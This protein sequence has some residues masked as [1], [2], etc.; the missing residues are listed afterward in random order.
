LAKKLIE[1]GAHIDRIESITTEYK[2]E[3]PSKWGY[4]TT[5]L[6]L[7][8]WNRNYEFAKYMISKG[9]NVNVGGHPNVRALQL[10]LFDGNF[11]FASILI[12]N[13]DDVN[14]V[15]ENEQT[16]L[17]FA[18]LNNN[19]NLVKFLVN[20]GANINLGTLNI[21]EGTG[22]NVP[23]MIAIKEQHYDIVEFLI[24]SR[25]KMDV[26]PYSDMPLI[27]YSILHSTNDITKFII[28]RSVCL[29]RYHKNQWMTPLVAALDIMNDNIA[30]YLLKKGANPN[31][32]SEYQN[33]TVYP[34]TVALETE[35]LHMVQ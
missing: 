28:D 32:Q 13:G 18:V 4:Y 21:H 22:Y 23:L 34:L 11:D 12:K 19:I 7:V 2:T 33:G 25:A 14:E 30:E 8:I 10:V 26:D 17:Q 20:N 31:T 5:S 6:F 35:N 29:D 24:N 9:A 15:Y 1:Y 27:T 3:M 16:L